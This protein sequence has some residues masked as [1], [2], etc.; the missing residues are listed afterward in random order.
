MTEPGTRRPLFEAI[1]LDFDQE[2]PEY[3][4]HFLRSKFFRRDD[5]ILLW[6]AYAP[7]ETAPSTYAIESG[8][9]FWKVQVIY[10]LDQR[11][12]RKYF[13]DRL[14]YWAGIPSLM[15]YTHQIAYICAYKDN[16]LFS[17]VY[18]RHLVGFKVE[19]EDLS[20]S[21]IQ[22]LTPY[23][24]IDSIMENF[25]QYTRDMIQSAMDTVDYCSRL[26]CL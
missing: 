12:S 7:E 1:P 11:R 26:Y 19:G 4:F 9:E 8:D 25:P 15:P 5:G 22:L 13:V 23:E 16:K 21:E 6:C 10:R 17:Y 20:E 14:H 24:M 3:H 2:S 18:Q